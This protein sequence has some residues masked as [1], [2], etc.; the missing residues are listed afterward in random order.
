MPRKS[1]KLSLLDSPCFVGCDNKQVN[2]AA[3][4]LNNV[5]E[6]HSFGVDVDCISGEVN[7]ILQ[8]EILP[9]DAF[10]WK[11]FV[12]SVY[13]FNCNVLQQSG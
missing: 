2:T 8:R 4:G 10:G 9:G 7:S 13:A 5:L 3:Y 11:I 12:M 6:V 1:G